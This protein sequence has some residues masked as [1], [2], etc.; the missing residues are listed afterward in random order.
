MHAAFYDQ[1][2]RIGKAIGNPGRLRLLDVLAQGGRT[3][4]ALA[5]E[6]ALTV[7][8]TSQHLRILAEARLVVAEKRGL[9]VHYRIAGAAVESLFACLQRTAAEQLAEV[10]VLAQKHLGADEPLEAVDRRELRRRIAAGEVTLID[11]RPTNEYLA[12]HLPG[13]LSVPLPDLAKHLTSLPRNRAVIA[14]CRGPYCAMSGKAV[15]ELT[16]R[17]F[18]ASRLPDGVL[19]WRNAGIPSVCG[20]TSA[21]PPSGRTAK[22]RRKP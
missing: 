11:V 22:V 13:A 12:G 8:N 2:A 5:G 1:F 6:S 17:G 14:Y 16:K 18:R 20:T 19:E 4:E 3:V 10:T 9:H 21:M 15:A 7:A